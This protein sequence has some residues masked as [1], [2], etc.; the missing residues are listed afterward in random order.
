MQLLLLELETAEKRGE[1]TRLNSVRWER[2]AHSLAAARAPRLAKCYEREPLGSADAESLVELEWHVG[3]DGRVRT[4]NLIWSNV[5]SAAALQ[6]MLDD[7]R[8]WSFE[9]HADGERVTSDP[10]SLRRVNMASR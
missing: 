10:F 7:A 2:N 1:E 8:T 3:P 4:L 6:C 9:A 5:A